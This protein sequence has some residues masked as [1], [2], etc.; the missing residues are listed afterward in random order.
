[1]PVK[2]KHDVFSLTNPEFHWPLADTLDQFRN[3]LEFAGGRLIRELSRVGWNVPGLEVGFRTYGRGEIQ[4]RQVNYIYGETRDGPFRLTFQGEQGKKGP[5]LITTGLS[6]A[7]IPPGREIEFNNY[8]SN[9]TVR[10][11]TGEDWMTDGSQWVNSIKSSAKAYGN[12]KQYLRYSG[13]YSRPTLRNDTDRGREYEPEGDEP[14]TVNAHDICD[15]AIAFVKA[16]IATLEKMP[17]A[18]GY[19]D[20]TPEGDANLRRLAHVEPIPA[21]S[22]FPTLFTWMD[23]NDAYRVARRLADHPYGEYGLSGND[24]QLCPIFSSRS[25]IPRDAR[26]MFSYATVDPSVR[27][28]HPLHGPGDNALPAVVQLKWLND[29]FVVDRAKFDQATKETFARI[30]A[31]GRD[32]MTD[33][34][35]D[36]CVA[37][38]AR[39]MVA[40]A[41]YKGGFEEPVYLIGRQTGLDEVRLVHG[42]V[43]ALQEGNRVKVIVHDDKADQDFSLF[44]RLPAGPRRLESAIRVAKEVSYLLSN[45]RFRNQLPEADDVQ[46]STPA[47]SP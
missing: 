10:L 18:P 43:T 36:D 28:G 4:I 45:G 2:F 26:R 40:A 19:D 24:A 47:C 29:V 21:P 42:P 12:P 7:A 8:S 35:L 11:Y 6:S 34:E 9:V 41:D 14:T 16:M 23:T 1:M 32:R 27:N 31:N 46:P 13:S 22:D 5:L 37:E 3:P 17:S 44:D 33:R 39:T 38:F 20:I 15:Q 30:L 25:D